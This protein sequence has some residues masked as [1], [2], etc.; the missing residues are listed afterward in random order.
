MF[1]GVSGLRN[2]GLRLS[3]FARSYRARSARTRSPLFVDTHANRGISS[4][5]R[6]L[7]GT[8]SVPRVARG[9]IV[10]ADT[11]RCR[12]LLH[13]RTS[14]SQMLRSVRV[15]V[16]NSVVT[17]SLGVMLRRLKRVANNRVDDRRALGGVFGRFYVKGW[18]IVGGSWCQRRVV[19]GILGVD[20]FLFDLA[21]NC[22]R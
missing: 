5:R 6:T 2:R 9:S 15:K 3:G 21:V 20:A 10:V 11:H 8:T 13:T 22:G 16:D 14:L 18:I 12:T 19:I 4:L 17:R 1:G 7:M